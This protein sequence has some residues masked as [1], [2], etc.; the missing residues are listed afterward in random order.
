VS[1]VASPLFLPAVPSGPLPGA[2]PL[3]VNLLPP[4]GA[5][6]GMT[7]A[8]VV[9]A[10]VAMAGSTAVVGEGRHVVRCKGLPFSATAASVATFFE[11]LVRA[12]GQSQQPAGASARGRTSA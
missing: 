3:Q 7:A 10:G 4:M 1:A 5:A 11:P 9:A 6:T 12:T 2:L 8:E